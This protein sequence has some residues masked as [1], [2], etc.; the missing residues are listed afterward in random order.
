M[1]HFKLLMIF[2]NCLLQK[3]PVLI[4]DFRDDI[5]KECEKF[6]E[7]KKVIVF[8][9]STYQVFSFLVYQK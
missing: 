3:N 9:V 5:K 8:D 2:L 7:V 4:T 1:A 6:G